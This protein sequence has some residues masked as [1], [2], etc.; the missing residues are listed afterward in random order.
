MAPGI[1]VLILGGTGDAADLTGKMSV[2]P[3]IEVITSLAGRTRQPS[4]LPGTVRVGG[5]VALPGWQLTCMSTI[6]IC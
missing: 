4:A 3:D 1:R 5:S 2:I 6:S